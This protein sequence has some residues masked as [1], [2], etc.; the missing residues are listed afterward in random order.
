MRVDDFDLVVMIRQMRD[1]I[2]ALLAEDS[3]PQQNTG[4]R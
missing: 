4:D 3:G 1:A 2:N